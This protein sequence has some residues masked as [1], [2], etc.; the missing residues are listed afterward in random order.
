[1]RSALLLFWLS[2]KRV[3]TLVGATGLLLAG[4]QTLRVLIASSL[5]E[6]GE[7]AQFADV[8]PP[9]VRAIIGPALSS[10]VSFNG[11]VC[12]GYYDLGIVLALVALTIALATLPASEI[13][14][15]F[16]DLILARPIRRHWLVTRTIVLTVL[17]IALMLFMVV[18]GSWFGVV[19][20]APTDVSLPPAEQTAGL[21]LNL[22]FL[23][24]AW[25]GI[26][27]ALGVAFHRAKAVGT[28][29]LMAFASL[30]L[31]YAQRLWTPL[32]SVGWISPFSYFSP[33]DL[34][35]GAPLPVEN[36]VVLG[37]IGATGWTLAYLVLTQRDILR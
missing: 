14:T 9:F 8:L 17:S 36:L 35:M 34:V 1:M 2:L 29:S 21:A 19:L 37:A 24:I 6:R 5:H 18:A 33:F 11:L 4:F 12:G 10:V 20:F 28:A 22:G 23:L 16:A 25:S 32:E 15:G 3:R 27:M 13:E 31:D 26:A 7:L 30:L